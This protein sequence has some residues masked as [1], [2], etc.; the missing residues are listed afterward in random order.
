MPVYPFK[1]VDV[2]SCKHFRGNP[3]AV[4]LNAEGIP[5]DEMQRIAAWTNLAET[6]F[7]LPPTAP[8]ADYHLRIFTPTVEMPFAGHPT[9]GSAH[10]A[11]EAGIVAPKDG[12]LRQECGIG[13]IDLSVENDG[14]ERLIF[15]TASPKVVYSFE[16]S[17]EAIS[18]AIGADI[19]L[20][21]FPMSVDVGAVWIICRFEDPATV[22]NLKPDMAAV[23]R[24]SDDFGVTGI[25][26][27]ALNS[28]AHPEEARRAVS[29]EAAIRVRCFAPFLGVPEDPVT[30][31]ANACIGRYFGETGL[32]DRVGREYISSQG[33]ELGREG[34]VHVRVSESGDQV[35]VGG[36]AITTIDGTIAVP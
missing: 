19:S 18:A 5:D 2:F 1:Q 33:T 22:R 24:L 21:P 27:F 29:K 4:V 25:A 17:A 26:T 12:R 34:R 13:I 28:P 35:Q 3:V 14:E 36:Q 9:I 23:A 10:A 31:S 32:V 15:F 7:L 30:G 8:E 6:T 16:E 20:E 11:I